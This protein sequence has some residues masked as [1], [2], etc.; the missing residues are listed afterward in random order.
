MNYGQIGLGDGMAAALDELGWA[1]VRDQVAGE[2]QARVAMVGLAGAGKSTLLNTLRGWEVSPVGGGPGARRGWEDWG[3]FVLV[4][5]PAEGPDHLAD[6]M[7]GEDLDGLC[8]VD[9]LLFLFDGALHC[10]GDEATAAE[11]QAARQ[12]EYRWYCRLRT[13]G[14]PVVAVLSKA[15]LWPDGQAAAAELA[16]RLAAPVTPLAAHDAASAIQVLLPRLLEAN[17]KLTVALGRELPVLRR[18]AAG[19]LI[20]QTTLYATLAGLQ[21][22][23]LLDLPVQLGLQMRLL[24]RLDALY[25]RSQQGDA[26]RELLASLAGG[27]AVR[28]SA[29]TLAKFVPVLGW[30]LA[31]ALSGLSAWALGWAAVAVLEGQHRRLVLSWRRRPVPPWRW[32]HR[33]TDGEESGP[34]YEAGPLLAELDEWF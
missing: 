20:R 4:D 18:P 11:R 3:M 33:L 22:V 32:A 5:L 30:A 28:L 12:G 31:G 6:E 14:P 26:S 24:L 16:Q 8:R 27:M 29:Q 21:P 23:P 13:L 19:R 10:D 15:D 17:P 1:H 9:L 7:L 2:A 34:A 25:G